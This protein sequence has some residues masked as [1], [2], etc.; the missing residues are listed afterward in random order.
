MGASDS[1]KNLKGMLDY[2][3][4][5]PERYARAKKTYSPSGGA[6]ILSGISPEDTGSE[7]SAPKWGDGDLSMREAS[8]IGGGIQIA[9]QIGQG[10]VQGQQAKQARE[11]YETSSMDAIAKARTQRDED[12]ALQKES[13]RQA[14]QEARFNERTA[15]AGVRMQMFARDLQKEM[16]KYADQQQA[17]NNL[18]SMSAGSE[19][20][21]DA[22]AQ[23]IGRA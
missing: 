18:R 20:Y 8:V 4:L 11:E 2:A 5:S 22:L 14:A 12:W 1:L 21:R 3:D 10:V 9:S 6:N 19:N 16:Q 17:M 7:D 13:D 23:R 15:N